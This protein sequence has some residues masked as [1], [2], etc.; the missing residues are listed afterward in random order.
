MSVRSPS[1]TSSPVHRVD[2]LQDGHALPG[3]RGLLDLERRGH[4]QA[5]VG[6]D[7]VAR[8]ERDDVARHELLCGDV[9]QRRRLAER[10][11]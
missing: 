2:R 1:G 11:P 5:P 10:A 4:E 3:Q 8:L 9:D 6:R 7:L